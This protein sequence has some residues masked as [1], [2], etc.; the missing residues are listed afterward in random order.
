MAVHSA[1]EEPHEHVVITTNEEVPT[2]KELNRVSGEL[3]LKTEPHT[4]DTSKL[5]KYLQEAKN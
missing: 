2:Q 1:F 5:E 4:V 3:P